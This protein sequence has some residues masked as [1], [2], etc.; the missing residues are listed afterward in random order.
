CP[1]TNLSMSRNIGVGMAAGDIVCFTDDDGIP[2]PDWLDALEAVYLEDEEVGAVGGYVRDHTGV[3]FQAREIVCNRAGD[4]ALFSTP[5]EAEKDLAES[6]G[7]YRSLIG[8]NSS[9]RKSALEAVGGFDEE[10]AY[11][12]EETDLCLRLLDHGWKVRVTP[13]AE[14]HHKFAASHLRRTD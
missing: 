7:H 9:F 2:E 1:E 13:D 12:L 14:V 11:F 4:A 3:A 10:Y 8:V 5:Q 6:P